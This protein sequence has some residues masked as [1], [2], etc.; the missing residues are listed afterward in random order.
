MMKYIS[1]PGPLSSC[2]CMIVHTSLLKGCACGVQITSFATHEALAFWGG[3]LLFAAWFVAAPAAWSHW[4][5]AQ[6]MAIWACALAVCG[7][8][9]AFMFQVCSISRSTHTMK[10]CIL[11]SGRVLNQLRS[12][13]CPMS[14]K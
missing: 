13:Y 4:G 9:L 8:T 3:K 11:T 2:H 14:G 1:S 5:L 7:W 10:L 6:L 12:D